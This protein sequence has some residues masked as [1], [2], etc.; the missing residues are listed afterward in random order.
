MLPKD[1]IR[2]LIQNYIDVDSF[3]PLM[4]TAKLFRCFTDAQITELYKKFYVKR[5]YESILC[6]IYNGSSIGTKAKHKKKTQTFAT[7][8]SMMTQ[9]VYCGVLVFKN[10]K[11]KHESRC[12]DKLMGVTADTNQNYNW[13][14]RGTHAGRRKFNPGDMLSFYGVIIP[15]K[16]VL[17]TC[18]YCGETDIFRWDMRD[19][20]RFCMTRV[21][22]CEIFVLLISLP[23]FSLLLTFR[24]QKARVVYTKRSSAT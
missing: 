22:K 9:C 21:T 1:I 20:F 13:R 12:L 3:G 14:R 17:L 15:K 4:A 16:R 7:F 11:H 6:K 5:Y 10:G 24:N 2:H 23:S 18:G 8:C 19:H